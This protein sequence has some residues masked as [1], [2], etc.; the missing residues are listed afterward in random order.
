M[1]IAISIGRKQ[2]KSDESSSIP[3]ISN[4]FSFKTTSRLVCSED[5][6]VKYKEN[7][8][9]SILSLR[10]PMDAAA[11]TILSD[12]SEPEEKRHRSDGGEDKSQ[13]KEIPTVSFKSCLD[14][15]SATLSCCECYHIRTTWNN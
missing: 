12:T 6:R 9:E 8:L 14:S 7:A 1:F 13:E 4:L 5:S 2:C 11:K 15:W 10:V 3:T